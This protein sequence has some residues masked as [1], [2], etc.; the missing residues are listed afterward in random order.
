MSVH[1]TNTP[2]VGAMHHT[3]LFHRLLD[4][5]AVGKQRRDLARLDDRALEDIGVSRAQAESE[6][7]RPAWDVP[8]HWMG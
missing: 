6:A 3:G 2:L 8:H 7:A 1:T 4:M 5:I